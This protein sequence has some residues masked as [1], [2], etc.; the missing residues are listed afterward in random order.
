MSELTEEQI[1]E[2]IYILDNMTILSS[3]NL[4]NIGQEDK[5]KI[6]KYNNNNII[7]YCNKFFNGDI[8]EFISYLKVDIDGYAFENEAYFSF[9][10]GLVYD[11]IIIGEVDDFNTISDYALISVIETNYKNILSINDNDF[12]ELKLWIFNNL[13]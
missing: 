6:Y 5:Y 12:N 1:D 7:E 3:I 9:C 10:D 11:Y 4:Y 2:L 8:T 13:L